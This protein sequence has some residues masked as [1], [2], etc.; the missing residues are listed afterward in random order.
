MPCRGAVD[1]PGVEVVDGD[2]GRTRKRRESLDTQSPSLG[3]AS[4]GPFG[5][6]MGLPCL[7]DVTGVGGPVEVGGVGLLVIME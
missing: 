7:V 6:G 4:G 2:E 3:R 1:T 5:P